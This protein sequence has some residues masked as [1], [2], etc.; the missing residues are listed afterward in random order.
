MKLGRSPENG[1]PLRLIAIQDVL[2]GKIFCSFG[3]GFS[4]VGTCFCGSSPRRRPCASTWVAAAATTHASTT[5]QTFIANPS[6]AWKTRGPY[7]AIARRSTEASGRSADPGEEPLHQRIGPAEDVVERAHGHV[8]CARDEQR[9]DDAEG[10]LG[11]AAQD[12]L[13]VPR[14]PV[15]Q[16]GGERRD[17]AGE[18]DGPR[19]IER[20]ADFPRRARLLL[21]RDA[22]EHQGGGGAG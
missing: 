11:P 2:V 4:P 6:P 19:G 13:A 16:G 12:E 1:L 20:G 22:R 7:G 17:H 21:G 5:R 18:V 15:G 14:R 3:G 10:V 9:V 8:L